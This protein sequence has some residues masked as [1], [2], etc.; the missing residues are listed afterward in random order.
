MDTPIAQATGHGNVIVGVYADRIELKSGLQGQRVESVGLKDISEVE[1]R[2][3]V[4]C[5]LTLSTSSGRVHQVQRLA[6]PEAARIKSA[7]E[8]QK[9]KAGLYE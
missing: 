5:T 4:N 8:S 2:G 3:V 1:V 9:Q 7:I 6:R